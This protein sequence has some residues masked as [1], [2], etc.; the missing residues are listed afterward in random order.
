MSSIQWF[1]FLVGAALFCAGTIWVYLGVKRREAAIVATILGATLFISPFVVHMVA[2]KFFEA[3]STFR[4][5][6]HMG[7]GFGIFVGGVFGLVFGA[8]SSSRQDGT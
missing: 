3:S 5:V 2:T 7:M 1:W 4:V 6:G 8:L